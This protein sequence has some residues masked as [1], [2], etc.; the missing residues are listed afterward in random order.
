MGEGL[1]AN[2]ARGIGDSNLDGAAVRGIFGGEFAINE[3]TL[4]LAQSFGFGHAIGEVFIE[5]QLF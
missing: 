3:V 1:G 5:L 2:L 4:N